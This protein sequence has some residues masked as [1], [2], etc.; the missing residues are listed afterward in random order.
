MRR[1]TE[2]KA[3]SLNCLVDYND[4][5]VNLTINKI[6]GVEKNGNKFSKNNGEIRGESIESR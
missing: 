1:V 6:R 4:K 5:P 3:K 2:A